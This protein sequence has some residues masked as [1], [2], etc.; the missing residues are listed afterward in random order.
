[1]VRSSSVFVMKA[2]WV[3]WANHQEPARDGVRSI[4]EFYDRELNPSEHSPQLSFRVREAEDLVQKMEAH[5]TEM[6]GQ[7][8]QAL[9][10][11]GSQKKRAEMLEVELQMLRRQASTVE[12]S[13]FLAKEEMD[14]LRL[15][16]EELETERSQLEE[17]KRCLEAKLDQATLQGYHDPSRTKILHF[18][19]NP[20]SLAKQ[21]RQDQMVSLREECERLRERIRILEGGDAGGT[22]SGV[23]EGSVKLPSQPEVAELKKQ[24]ESAELKNQRLKEIFGTKIQEFRKVCYK[25]TGYNIDITIEN[26]YRLKSIYAEHRE[27]CLIFK[28]SRS[29][30]AKMQLLETEFSQTVRDLIDL[31][32]LQQDSI[33]AF[34][35][36][37]TLELFSRQTVA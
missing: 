11:A 15:K 34:L 8:S 9:E 32:L 19:M 21:Q 24:L 36:A 18:S 31:H 29:S 1:M 4:L 22:S 28:T 23:L 30:G 12:P 5:C 27:D 17:E 3:T 14:T 20:A 33:P 26:Q 35:S 13:N 10:E 7:L 16:I 6:E 25:L 2:N 37:V